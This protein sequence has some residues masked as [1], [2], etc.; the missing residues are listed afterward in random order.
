MSDK[1]LIEAV[2]DLWVSHGGDAEG[3]DWCFC[4]LKDAVSERTNTDEQKDTP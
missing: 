2:A 1:E 3:L 4:K